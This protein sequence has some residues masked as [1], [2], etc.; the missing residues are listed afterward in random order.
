MV[1]KRNEQDQRVNGIVA[2]AGVVMYIQSN[3]IVLA[4]L[5]RVVCKRQVRALIYSLFHRDDA[6]TTI[7]QVQAE[8]GR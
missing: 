2:V 1:I 5:D 6:P 7:D 8:P 3:S 4:N